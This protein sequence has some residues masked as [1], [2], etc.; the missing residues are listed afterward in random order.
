M[1]LF[2]VQ[3]DDRPAYV[4]ADDFTEA[5]EKWRHAVAADNDGECFGPDGVSMICD[6]NE[7]IVDQEWN[8]ISARAPEDTR[9]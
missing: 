7:L 3:D 4:V 2:H 8:D 5:I 1:P 6:D 9:K